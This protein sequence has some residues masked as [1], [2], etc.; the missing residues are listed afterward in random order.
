[1]SEP[2]AASLLMTFQG[3]RD[4]ETVDYSA[5][6]CHPVREEKPDVADVKPIAEVD[7]QPHDQKQ[8]AITCREIPASNKPSVSTL[9]CI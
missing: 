9:L 4:G 8:V 6:V 2:L 3:R 5:F 1:M 7:Q